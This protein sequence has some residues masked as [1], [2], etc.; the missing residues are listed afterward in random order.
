[1]PSPSSPRS[2]AA[3]F[4]IRALVLGLCSYGMLY[5]AYKYYQ[6]WFGGN[7]FADYYPAYLNPFHNEAVDPFRFRRLSA[8]VTFLI[9]EAGIYYPAEIAFND[10]AYSQR[11][12]FAALLSNYIALWSA[13]MVC[14]YIATEEGASP[15]LSGLLVFAG[16]G[17]QAFVLTGLTEGWSWL[18]VAL[19]F[20]FYTRR[21]YRC[22]W[23]V[24]VASIFQ[25][26]TILVVF[27]TFACVDLW[28]RRR[29]KVDR[30][31]TMTIVVALAGFGGYLVL[32]WVDS[33]PSIH[34]TQLYPSYLWEVLRG[35]APS[36]A[37]GI[38]AFLTQNLL[39]LYGVL[40][41]LL[42]FAGER[43]PGYGWHLAAA[44]AALTL[45]GVAAGIGHNTGRIMT[46]LTPIVAPLASAAL[47]RLKV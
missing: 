31:M 34:T 35:F 21:H 37:F 3:G 42:R 29:E 8:L 10:P 32:R 38:Q 25:R 2:F 5:F 12:Y 39:V 17:A 9:H 18:L 46:V 43:S 14:S 6:P 33:V 40:A 24:L 36:P 47:M 1:M 28:L 13:A 7:D 15:L 41:I 22:L 20:F 30:M 4:A 26:E 23:L 45:G 16:F 11:I 27:G 44:V 19:G